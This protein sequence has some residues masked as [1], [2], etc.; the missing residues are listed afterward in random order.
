VEL[1]E[2]GVKVRRSVLV[3]IQIL[4]GLWIWG[5]NDKLAP[6]HVVLGPQGGLNLGSTPSRLHLY[7]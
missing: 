5:S 2:T 3:T 1:A 6:L 7:V 4:L